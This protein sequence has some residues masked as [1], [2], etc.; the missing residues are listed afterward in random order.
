MR[1]LELLRFVSGAT[2]ARLD[3]LILKAE[4]GILEIPS[5]P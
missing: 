1:L 4:S 3:E 5:P 2:A